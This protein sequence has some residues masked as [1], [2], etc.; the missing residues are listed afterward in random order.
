MHQEDDNEMSTSHQVIILIP[1][2]KNVNKIFKI[3]D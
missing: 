3:I 1:C 2:L